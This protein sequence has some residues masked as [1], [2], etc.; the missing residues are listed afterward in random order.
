MARLACFQADNEG[1]AGSII[2]QN[3]DAKNPKNET[4]TLEAVEE[5]QNPDQ[6]VDDPGIA[7]VQSYLLYG[8]SLPERTLR[9]TTAATPWARA[10]LRPRWWA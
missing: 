8:L 6:P 7:R 9:S 3:N 10:W 1:A 2:M 5:G 4:D